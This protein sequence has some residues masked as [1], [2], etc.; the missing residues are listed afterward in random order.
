M[1]I[2]QS[3]SVL[4]FAVFLF[5]LVCTFQTSKAQNW[6]ALNPSEQ[7]NYRVDSEN[8]ITTVIFP[9]SFGWAGTDSVYYLNRIVTECYSCLNSEDTL[10][11]N[12]PQFLMRRAI[13]KASGLWNFC[14]T[15]N[16]ALYTWAAQ[17]ATW[18]LDSNF[19]V[20]ALVDT[21]YA[22]SIFA[23]ADSVKRILLSTGDTILLSREHGILVWPDGYGSGMYHRLVG[24]KGRNL[25]K[26]LPGFAGMYDFGVGDIFQVSLGEYECQGPPCYCWDYAHTYK[27]TV[28]SVSQWG[29]TT[30]VY[31]HAL[32]VT[33][34][35]NGCTG[36]TSS[37]G[38]Q[39]G[40]FIV[41]DSANHFVNHY[42]NQLLSLYQ[43]FFGFF[44][45]GMAVRP[46]SETENYVV[47]RCTY[48]DAGNG[49]VGMTA[50]F[51]A[52]NGYYQNLPP[53]SPYLKN[54]GWISPDSIGYLEG[55]GL[56]YYRWENFESYGFWRCDGYFNG[57]DTIG[58]LTPDSLLWIPMGTSSAQSFSVQAYPNPAD[59]YIRFSCT[60]RGGFQNGTIRLLAL[61]GKVMDEVF[62]PLGSRE[63]NV[64]V[65]RFGIGIYFWEYWNDSGRQEIRR[66]EVMR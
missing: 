34:G 6:A 26:L 29:D 48:H 8:I 39:T 57:T 58:F 5:C 40:S 31:F 54:I 10:F 66:F 20:Q 50:Y 21:V 55:M 51:T 9:D 22:D 28:D 19:A 32:V 15:A 35:G 27:G 33:Y 64:D 42:P 45:E 61:D 7:F 30:E 18:L 59:S 65:S 53:G 24:I 3:Y 62:L 25:G 44:D 49:R 13:V 43:R 38:S 46:F 17:G 1:K 60:E 63:I 47:D 56:Q 12:Q 14:D 41:V 37:L 16:I 36:Y 2:V 52:R 4:R 11:M 23:Q